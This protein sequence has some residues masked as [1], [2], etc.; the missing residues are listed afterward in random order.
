M[1][2]ATIDACAAAGANMIVSGD[3]AAAAGAAGAGADVYASGGGAAAAAACDGGFKEGNP[4]TAV[5]R[6]E[7]PGEVMRGLREAV[8]ARL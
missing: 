1:G 6:A 2:P 7:K 5:V 8:A 4:G 3:G